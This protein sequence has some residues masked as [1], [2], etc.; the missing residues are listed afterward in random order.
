M[1]MVGYSGPTW[2]VCVPA[3]LFALSDISHVSRALFSPPGLKWHVLAL[4]LASCGRKTL[5]LSI[6]STRSSCASPSDSARNLKASSF[7]A[8]AIIQERN[9]CLLLDNCVWRGCARRA[10]T[11]I[12]RFWASLWCARNGAL[13][14]LW[15]LQLEVRLEALLRKLVSINS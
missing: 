9:A 5:H 15:N 2:R 7:T 4:S 11:C 1:L 3:K 10:S 6:G 13:T 12:T 14:V 8:M